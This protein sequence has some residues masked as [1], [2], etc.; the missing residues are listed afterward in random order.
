MGISLNPS[1]LKLYGEVAALLVKYGNGDLVRQAGLD[2][3]LPEET[4][5]T[6]QGR[7]PE[8]AELAA[9][10]ER[11]GPTFVKLGQLLSTRPDLLP[12]PYIDALSRLQDQL[13][14]FPF[15][16]VERI[17][18]TE[19]DAPISELF[20]WFD[21]EPLAAAS[22]GQVHRAELMDGRSVAV[23]V[24]RPG[25]RERITTD[26]EALE[27]VVGFLDRHTE[28]GRRYGVA[29]ILEE[30][31]KSILGELDYERE[32]AN[33]TTLARNLAE[34]D[35][36][37]IPVAIGGHTTSRVLTME[38]VRGR[39]LTRLSRLARCEVDGEELAEQ[40]FQAYL[41]QILVDGFF[42]ADPHPGNVFLTDDGRLALLDVGMVGRL[43]PELRTRLLRFMLAIG[44]GRAE[45]AAGV[46]VQIGDPQPGRFDEKAF[47]RSVAELV[48]RHEAL[49]AEKIQLGRIVIELSR[50]AGECGVWLPEEFPT[51]GRALLALDRVG[52]TLD[53][54]LDPNAAIRSNAAEILRRRL[55]EYVSPAHV[56]DQLLELN[57]F[58]QRFPAR[59]NQVTDAL[60]RNELEIGI[61]VRDQ[62]WL[63]EGLQKI[64]NRIA[65]GLVLAALIVGAAML[66]RVDTTWRILGY[67]AVAMVLFLAA[68]ILGLGL[69]VSTLVNDVRARHKD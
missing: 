50:S 60:A 58:I 53:P 3:A 61:R 68:A 22:L 66:M 52:R 35:R 9:D 17:V 64:S 32:A 11:L 62:L 23:K 27:E 40:L 30:F 4:P 43:T 5:A 42:H 8:A 7:V 69:V 19:L 65:T 47:T 21:R 41:K 37:Y 34:F 13:E 1:H 2:E 28:V 45:D 44:E 39:K 49:P 24:Q 20:C 56:L 15:E 54:T 67:P 12:E 38:Y 29:R 18:S 33:M 10:L 31:R 55:L 46:M 59:L 51:L 16:E 36:I 25:I 57:E 48:L 6:E 14:P 26:M 63:T